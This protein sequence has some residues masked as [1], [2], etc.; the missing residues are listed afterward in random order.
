MPTLSIRFTDE[1]HALIREIADADNRPIS[2]FIVTAAVKA[3]EE[4]KRLPVYVYGGYTYTP[5]E[6]RTYRELPFDWESR[7]D[8]VMEA[9]KR[10]DLREAWLLSLAAFDW[11]MFQPQLEDAVHDLKINDPA[12]RRVDGGL[13]RQVARLFGVKLD[14]RR[15]TI[16]EGLQTVIEEFKDP[17]HQ[18]VRRRSG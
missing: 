13:N 10:S 8:D 11:P 9:L 1:Q 14:I 4:M 6:Y 15:A 16:A 12:S 7:A 17:N 5:Q 3:A 18:L 2:N